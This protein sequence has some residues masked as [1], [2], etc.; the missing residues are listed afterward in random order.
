MGEKWKL[1]RRIVLIAISA[2]YLMFAFRIGFWITGDIHNGG[3]MVG[4]L[5]FPIFV[6][7][8]TMALY[9]PERRTRSICAM[10]IGSYLLVGIILI[11]VLR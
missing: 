6:S 3:Q 2:V 10:I 5:L 4:I 9:W 7:L 11:L 8:V 1:I